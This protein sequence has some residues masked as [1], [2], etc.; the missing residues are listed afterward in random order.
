[1]NAPTE[2]LRF[3]SGHTVRR[4]EDP[5][6]ITGRGQFT[7]DLNRTGQAHW[8]SCA[9]RMHMPRSS[10]STPTRRARCPACWRS[11]PAPTC[12]PPA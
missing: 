2:T 3:G 12:W 1:M 8:C 11:I 5:T 6:L 4:L 9:R 7:D 10:R